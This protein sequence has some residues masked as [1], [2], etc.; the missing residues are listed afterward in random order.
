MRKLVR[1]LILF[2]IAFLIESCSKSDDNKEINSGILN[3]NGEEYNLNHGELVKISTVV[4]GEVYVGLIYLLST[5][6][7]YGNTTITGTG[8]VIEL[9]MLFNSLYTLLPGTYTLTT[10]EPYHS[11]TF[12]SNFFKDL[13]VSTME[14]IALYKATSG[15]IIVSK[16][17]TT[18]ELN[19][20]VLADKFNITHADTEPTESPV[21]TNIHIT[22]SYKGDLKQKYLSK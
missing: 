10:G 14:I 21:A 8:Q 4:A 6:Y 12:I 17:G 5:D 15:N 20:D 16:S 18:Y 11:M 22:C 7:N 2:T 3:I 1:L 19:I 13:N 9:K